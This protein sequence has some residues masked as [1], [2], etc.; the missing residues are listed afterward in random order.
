[1]KIMADNQRGGF[2]KYLHDAALERA[3]EKAIAPDLDAIRWEGMKLVF[4]EC[5]REAARSVLLLVLSYLFIPFLVFS[6]EMLLSLSLMAKRESERGE[7]LKARLIE[8]DR[9]WKKR[10][11]EI[12]N[13]D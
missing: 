4:V 10:K 13:H 8:L 5:P 11:K 1:M 3:K 7:R 6:P 9:K 2:T 12:Q